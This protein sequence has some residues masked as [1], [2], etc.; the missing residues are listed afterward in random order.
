MKR[1]LRLFV[2]STKCPEE[3]QLRAREREIHKQSKL[4][5]KKIKELEKYQAARSKVEALIKQAA[6]EHKG[7]AIIK[8]EIEQEKKEELE[9]IN[10]SKTQL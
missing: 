4:I 10:M 9:K 2:S 1:Q 8:K 3:S 7:L 5:Q 6:K